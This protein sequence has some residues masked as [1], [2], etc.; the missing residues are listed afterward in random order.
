MGIRECRLGGYQVEFAM[1]FSRDGSFTTPVV[2]FNAAENNDQYLGEAPLKEMAIQIAAAR[3]RCGFNSE[4]LTRIANFVKENI[5]EDK[6]D[7]LFQLDELVKEEL[8]RNG[9]HWKSQWRPVTATCPSVEAILND[10]KKPI[11]QRKNQK[12]LVIDTAAI[13]SNEIPSQSQ[14]SPY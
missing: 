10:T 11:D 13:T 5:P 14:L 7:H 3:G 8:A 6:D 2:V 4:Y 12:K 1:F 9:I